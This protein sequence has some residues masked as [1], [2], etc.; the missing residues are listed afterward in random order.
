MRSPYAGLEGNER[1]F[2]FYTL[3]HILGT[4]VIRS[5]RVLF[6][7]LA[8]RVYF[9]AAAGQG[10]PQEILCSWHHLFPRTE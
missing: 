4:I 3:S 2:R 10:N 8:G 6:S 1:Y 5:S 7:S 9:G